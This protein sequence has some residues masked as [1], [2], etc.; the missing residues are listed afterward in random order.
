MYLFY[1]LSRH[2]GRLVDDQTRGANGSRLVFNPALYGSASEDSDAT[3]N[4]PT[5]GGSV[6]VAIDIDGLAG[7]MDSFIWSCT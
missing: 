7:A 4:L 6:G 1:E 3:Q 2:V 5:I